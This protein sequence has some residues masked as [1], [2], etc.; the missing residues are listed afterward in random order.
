[1]CEAMSSGLVVVTNKVAAV[2]EYIDDTVGIL[3]DYEDYLGMADAIEGL[4]YD[5]DLFCNT[6]KRLPVP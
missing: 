3:C 4:Y 5:R 2:P 6:Q 1:M